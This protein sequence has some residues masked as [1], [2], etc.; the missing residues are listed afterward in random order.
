LSIIVDTA[1]A[2]V[3]LTHDI[4]LP[5]QTY[6]MISFTV[7][8]SISAINQAMAWY[9]TQQFLKS[10]IN[11]NTKVTL[12]I[13]CEISVPMG[14]ASLFALMHAITNNFIFHCLLIAT[15]SVAVKSYSIIII[16]SVVFILRLFLLGALFRAKHINMELNDS[17]HGPRLTVSKMIIIEV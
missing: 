8:A 6:Q 5:V 1:V 9:I 10:A 17:P 2:I 12:Q 11:Y 3:S 15:A 4:D 16:L 14:I 7:R 13:L